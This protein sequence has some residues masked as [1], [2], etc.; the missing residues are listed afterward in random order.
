[1]IFKNFSCY[2]KKLS[3]CIKKDSYNGYRNGKDTTFPNGVILFSGLGYEVE[4]EKCIDINKYV[5][6]L[7]LNSELESSIFCDLVKE[8]CV[9]SVYIDSSN[10]MV[11][12][13]KSFEAVLE[14]INTSLSHLEIVDPIAHEKL[15]EDTLSFFSK[16][17]V[18]VMQEGI[19]G[20]IYKAG[21]IVQSY[22][23]TAL[24]VESIMMSRMMGVTGSKVFSGQPLLYIALPTVGGIF[25]HGASMIFGENLIGSSCRTLGNVL[26]LPMKGTELVLNNIVLHP[27]GKIT[28]IPMLLNMTQAINTGPGL[29]IKDAKKVIDIVQ[30]GKLSPLWRKLSSTYEIWFK[31]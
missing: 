11:I 1:M 22:G 5:D 17:Q 4:F 16:K 25:F 20:A 10:T 28:G 26:L 21:Q 18:V 6:K 13:N 29:S 3:S 9:G 14:T 23:S 19:Q 12:T 8:Q 2:I 24:T 31:K 30:N 7:N 27:L 15:I